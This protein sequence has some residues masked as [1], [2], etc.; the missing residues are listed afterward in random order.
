MDEDVPDLS[1]VPVRRVE[2]RPD[3]QLPDPQVWPMTVPAVRQLLDEGLDLGRCT[4][5]VGA[6][7]AGKSTIVEAVA[8][9]FGLGVE[10]GSTG[11]MH[12]T[13]RSES[14]LQDWLRLVRGPGGSRWGYFVRAETMH[15]LFTYLQDVTYE[16]FHGRSHGEAF[17]DLLATRRYE[18][19]GLFVWDEPEAGLSFDAQLQLV[20]ELTLIAERPGSQVLLATHSPVLAAIPGARLVELSEE[21]MQQVTWEELALVDHYRRFLEAPQ[22]Y[23]RHLLEEVES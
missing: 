16:R 19:D 22:R 8:G 15:G 23:L 9:A 14:P 5:L 2:R 18:G 3:A 10:G 17:L 6:N 4:V 12:A 7:G 20:A 21:G 11:S 13:A 1:P